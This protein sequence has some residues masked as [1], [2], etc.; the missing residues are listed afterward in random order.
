MKL[1]LF[2][3][4]IFSAVFLSVVL[5]NNAYA[6]QTG[7][8]ISYTFTGKFMLSNS[9]CKL[10][11]QTTDLTVDFQSVIEK[12]LYLYNRTKSIP[13]TINLTG[14]DTTVN[15]Q[16]TFTFKGTE[17]TK[18]PGL[19]AV[20]GG[21]T[22]IAVGLEYQDGTAMPINKAS[23][24]ITLA[25]GN[26]SITFLAYVIGEPDA[27]QQQSITPGAFSVTATFEMSYP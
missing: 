24:E 23:S 20:T 18:S 27:I 22:G 5:L 16:V 8:D 26:N 7:D 15:N 25:G 2:V 1:N 3:T 12:D 19:L 21:A 4:R 11:P 10:D 6:A 17:S 9:P 14:C 13:L